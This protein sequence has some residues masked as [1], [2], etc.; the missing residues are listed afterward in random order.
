VSDLAGNHQFVGRSPEID[1]IE[2]AVADARNGTPSVLLIGGE[3]GIGKSRLIREGAAHADITLYLGRCMHLGGDSIPL[4]PLADV[5]RQIRRGSPA[6]A[7][8][9]PEFAVLRRWLAPDSHAGLEAQRGHGSLFLPV[10]ELVGH[11]AAPNGLA[12]GFEDLHWADMVT[13]DLFEFL[14]RNLVDERVVLVGTY[15]ANEISAEPSQRRRMG[16]LSRLES[17]RRIHLV[18]LDRDAVCARVADLMGEPAPAEFVDDILARGQGNPFFTEELVAAHLAGVAIPAVLSDLISGDIAGLDDR[19]RQVLAAVAA[20]GR[21]VSHGLLA[22][23]ADLGDE[24]LETAVRAAIDAQLLVVDGVTDAYRF[25][26]ALLGEVVYADLLPPQ[27]ARLH[28]RVAEA[29]QEK[30]AGQLTRA[31]LAGELAFH[32]DRAGHSEAAFVALLAAA[33]AAETVAPGVALRHLE[34]A[35]ELWDAVDATAVGARRSDRMWQAAEL[36]SG[37]VGNQRAAALARAGSELGPHPRG[38]AFGHERLGRY[39]WSSGHLQ[40][41]RAEFEKA[42]ALLPREP[43]P[44]A[45]PVFAGL[46]QADLMSGRYESAERWCTKVFDLVPTPDPDRL[47]WVM[48]RRVLGVARSHLGEPD[49]AV[50]LCREARAAAPDAHSR[51]LASIYLGAVLLDAGVTPEAVK[52][53]LDAVAETRLSGLDR[54]FG[55]YLDALAAEGLT[56]LGRWPEAEAVIVRHTATEGF[57]LGVLRVACAGAR[58]AARR[59]EADRARS[60]L[61]TARAQPCDGMHRSFLDA[62]T[63]EVHLVLGEW[64]E[65][66]AAAEHG[67]SSAP[68]TTVLWS[69]RFA[70]LSAGAAV[71]LALDARARR[72]SVDVEATI[73]QLR[74]RLDDV[75]HA[76]AART[77]DHLTVDAAAHLAHADASLT[78]LTAP[79]PDAWAEAAQRW[80]DLGDLWGVA[81]ARMH[82]ADA[83]AATGEAA[84]AATSLREAHRIAADLGAEPILAEV[85]AVSRRTR[86][87]VDLPTRVALDATTVDRLGLT[88]R[89]TEVLTLVAAGQTN[90]QIGAEL[91]VSE[92]TAGVHVSNILRKLGVTSRVDA[93]AVA[94]RLGVA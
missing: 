85:D 88:A 10:L 15:R 7:D 76:A 31:D 84:R 21:P 77:A 65:A 12:V 40:E 67:W 72:E 16:E 47:A 1:S 26:H 36:A 61:A 39:L 82:E 3:A 41:S 89:E 37:T 27:R 33:D 42:A 46:G 5:L 92:K 19:T 75:R 71:E 56:R 80:G 25:R 32:L 14:A 93:A 34:R 48:A 4:A 23:V 6:V 57:P 38:E 49:E 86:I 64:T 79:D 45:A 35:F 59:G 22:N 73:A 13:W 90:R 54:I 30:S 55:G 74:G 62:V 11:L 70:M 24:A 83:A 20:V 29:L 52:A 87:S 43:G 2:R 44:E 60:F 9:S 69:A 53:A 50:E 8:D 81:V 28:R 18:G 78:R 66:A 94:Q 58:L 17:V 68:V 63:A 51:A 91:F